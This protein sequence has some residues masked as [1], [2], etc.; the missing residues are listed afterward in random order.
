MST[1][2]KGGPESG[3]N[4]VI[5]YEDTPTRQWAGEVCQRVA[6]LVGAEA[7]RTT[8]WKLGELTEPAVL[9]GAVSTALR[10]DVLVVA[11][12]AAEALPLAFYVW[13][14]SWLP[15]RSSRLAALVGLIALPRRPNLGWDH[16][17]DYLRAV[18]RESQLDFLL[19]ERKLTPAVAEAVNETQRAP[20]RGWPGSE[21][22]RFPRRA[23]P[24]PESARIR[25][26][27][28]A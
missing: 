7:V 16:A 3:L 19:E 11:I 26:A 13:V 25:S 5:V 21:G 22:G 10:A 27:A 24:G 15:H 9:A 20:L 2:G 12:H 4:L 18:A 17:Q 6:N 14:Q 28:A 8:W 1:S 23:S